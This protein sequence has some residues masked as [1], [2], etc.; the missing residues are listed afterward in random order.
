MTPAHNQIGDNPNIVWFWPNRRMDIDYT[1]L[2]VDQIMELD[3]ECDAAGWFK[4][5]GLDWRASWRGKLAVSEFTEPSERL[6]EGL[7]ECAVAWANGTVSDLRLP[8][9]S[10]HRHMEAMSRWPR[11]DTVF[12]GYEDWSRSGRD[13]FSELGYR[14][15]VSV[16]EMERYCLNWIMRMYLWSRDLEIAELN[17]AV[18][19]AN[20]VAGSFRT[21]RRFIVTGTEQY[22]AGSGKW[23]KIDISA[24]SGLKSDWSPVSFSWAELLMH[25]D[26]SLGLDDELSRFTRLS[27]AG[28]GDIESGRTGSSASRK[29][30]NSL[31]WRLSGVTVSRL[32]RLRGLIE[33]Q[34][35]SI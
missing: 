12:F 28:Y 30:A 7:E 35:I 13:A 9:H 33:S 29:R 11:R 24:V 18:V 15:F 1:K 27:A 20:P 2:E 26:L 4:T 6:I 23:P 5:S 22:V 3:R 34:V 21:L 17:G 19:M 16:W 8:A 25:L 14:T 31:R 32:S 10:W